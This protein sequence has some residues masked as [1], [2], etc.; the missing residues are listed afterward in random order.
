MFLKAYLKTCPRILIWKPASFFIQLQMRNFYKMQDMLK[1]TVEKDCLK[2][3]HTLQIFI[4]K[5]LF[6]YAFC[7]LP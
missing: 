4:V 6:H 1:N 3:E 2:L 7:V 5:P